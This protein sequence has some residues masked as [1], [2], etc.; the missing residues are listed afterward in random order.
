VFQ[1]EGRATQLRVGAHPVPRKH[2]AKE[3]HTPV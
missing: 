2:F 1:T 3:R